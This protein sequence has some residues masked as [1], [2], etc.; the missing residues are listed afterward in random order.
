[1]GVLVGDLLNRQ[2]QA[3]KEFAVTFAKFDGDQHRALC[4]TLFATSK[5]V[6]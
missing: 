6:L 4:K 2:Q 5:K 1:M 3:R